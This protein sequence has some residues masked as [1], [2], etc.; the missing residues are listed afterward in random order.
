M[1]S[2]YS[3]EVL[4]RSRKYRNSNYLDTPS[5]TDYDS[6]KLP[7]SEKVASQTVGHD[8]EDQT[9]DDEKN[10][11]CSTL[12]RE[13][14]NLEKHGVHLDHVPLNQ[15]A[16]LR[17]SKVTIDDR[18]EPLRV[19]EITHDRHASVKHEPSSSIPHIHY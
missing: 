10:Q 5:C 9:T 12:M 4:A 13:L 11:M 1:N 16:L 18:A 3:S 6:L 14:N 19:S 7:P 8:S 17:D 2:T 15:S